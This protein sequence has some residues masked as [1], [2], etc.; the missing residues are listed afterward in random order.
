MGLPSTSWRTL[1]WSAFSDA[2]CALDARLQWRAASPVERASQD[3]WVSKL[4]GTQYCPAF[5]GASLAWPVLQLGAA[6][7]VRLWVHA[8]SERG[9]TRAREVLGPLLSATIRLLQG[10]LAGA[11]GSGAVVDVTYIDHPHKRMLPGFSPDTHGSGRGAAFEAQHVN[12]GVTFF[13]ASPRVLVYRRE[14]AGKV[15]V[16]ELLHLS[17]MDA[18]LRPRRH[19]AHYGQSV[20]AERELAQEFGIITGAGG[21][22]GV[23][24]AYTDA[25]ACYLHAVWGARRRGHASPQYLLAR[26]R[27]HIDLVAARVLA[28]GR[29]EHTHVFAYYVI[30]CA[31]WQDLPAF[32]RRYPAN[33]PPRDPVGFCRY[34]AGLLRALH[35][36]RAIARSGGLRMTCV[37]DVRVQE[38]RV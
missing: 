5:V 10:A 38:V 26:V 9:A 24:E 15:L 23:N 20:A 14:D 13:G 2:Q 29:R 34:V 27:A 11:L 8:R 16:H 25:L 12:G 33:R 18:G 31:L 28:H 21:V 19:S 30:K 4:L 22:V 6:P 7:G 17:D 37:D 1:A 36:P 35:L 3:Q 32:L